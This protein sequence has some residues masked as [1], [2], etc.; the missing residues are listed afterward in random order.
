[1]VE[2]PVKILLIDDHR[3]F[4][5][6]TRAL[7]AASKLN[8]DLEWA[9]T[10]QEGL[11]KIIQSRH[12]AYLIDYSLGEGTG[13]E[14]VRHARAHGNDAPMIILTGRVDEEIDMEA[15]DA[16]AS[17]YLSKGRLE[18][19]LL[20]RSIR[21][22]LEQK[23]MTD[24]LRESNERYRHIVETAQEGILV[25]DLNG[26]VAFANARIGELLGIPSE[27]MVGRPLGDFTDEE[28][29]RVMAEKFERRRRGIVECYD[30]KYIHASGS[31][32]WTIISASP[33][34]DSTGTIVATLGMVAD[35]TDRHHA[36]EALREANDRLEHRVR[37]RTAELSAALEQLEETHGAQRQF[38]ID[39]SHD[40]RTPLTVIRVEL[41]I[42][43]RR[44]KLNSVIAESLS[45]IGD[46][47]RRLDLLA[48]D[49]L[50]MARLESG[51]SSED[52]R[53]V[54]LD[55]L[56]LDC[57]ESLGPMAKEKEIAWD[58]D[59]ADPVEF[60]CYPHAIE[61][62]IFNILENAIKYSPDASTIG[63]VLDEQDQAAKITVADNGTGIMAQ[64]VP[65]V[66][67]RFFRGNRTRHMAGTGLG[68]SIVKAIVE[69]HSGN[70]ALESQ[71]ETGTTVHLSLP[72]GRVAA[73]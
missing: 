56:L 26:V 44:A 1:M 29:R 27:A 46:Q 11:D 53:V 23:R 2:S 17:D 5:T 33:I 41:D 63:V 71:P 48:N 19:R 66:F 52:L 24:A 30:F 55:E 40:L 38:F 59:I 34:R 70:V 9:G 60:H 32:I 51:T 69:A 21:Y 6:L 12:D 15:L 73:M 18:G 13:V 14:I 58:I 67:E 42:L 61:R 65:Y 31:P 16:G 35:I 20:E 54:R 37:E 72:L 68:L 43:L 25:A 4:F 64:D 62:A 47:V 22:A 28:G 57:I 8:V 36:Q 39:A 7:L 10:F 50:L 3:P 45:S 49:L